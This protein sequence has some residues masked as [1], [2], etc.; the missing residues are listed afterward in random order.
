MR[1]PVLEISVLSAVPH[2][3]QGQRV[4]RG[5]QRANRNVVVLRNE[6][7]TKA[8]ELRKGSNQSH[9][10]SHTYTGLLVLT[11]PI[12]H[13]DKFIIYF[14]H[15]ILFCYIL[16]FAIIILL[17][18]MQKI[19]FQFRNCLWIFSL[20]MITFLIYKLNLNLILD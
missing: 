20:L 7:S 8:N 12:F 18:I 5:S 11:E 16:N 13:D 17:R 10:F 1:S 2:H 6:N 3:L 19:E 14:L 15:F 9:I 4:K